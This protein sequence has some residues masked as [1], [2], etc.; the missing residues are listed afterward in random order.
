MSCLTLGVVDDSS[1]IDE[2]K[3]QNMPDTSSKSDGI[4]LIRN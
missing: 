4:S 2:L 3:A 1:F